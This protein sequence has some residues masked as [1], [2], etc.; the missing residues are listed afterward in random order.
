MHLSLS[1]E[2]KYLSDFCAAERSF[3]TEHPCKPCTNYITCYEGTIFEQG[4][5]RGTVFDPSKRDCNWPRDVPEC[6]NISNN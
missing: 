4:C 2:V 5:P 6:Q 3:R 1:N